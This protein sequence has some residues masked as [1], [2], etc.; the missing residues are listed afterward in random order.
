MEIKSLTRAEAKGAREYMEDTSIVSTISSVDLNGTLLA[1][2]DGHGGEFVSKFAAL[3]VERFFLQSEGIEITDRLFD[4][5][6]LLSEY[7]DGENLPSG[8]T[9]SIV[10]I[11]H[12]RAEAHVAVLGDSPVLV[13]SPS[14][15]LWQGPDHNV[16]SNP[17]EQAAAIARGGHMYGGYICN[18]S[19][20]GLQMGRA[21]GNPHLK[22]ILSRTPE[23]FTVDIEAGG[24]LLVA[25]DGLFDPGHQS[26]KSLHD[27]SETLTKFPQVE[28]QEL[29]DGALA[30]RTGD[31]VTA[32]LARF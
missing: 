11:D 16:R 1:V 24:W 26:D 9:A 10:Y 7:V 14:K 5:I 19:G 22:S 12:G 15:G 31:N 30:R 13:Y 27:V 6:A 21:L 20:Q 18:R 17:E 2:F 4:T 23:V 32:I 28:A 3:H 29:V 8:S 25:S